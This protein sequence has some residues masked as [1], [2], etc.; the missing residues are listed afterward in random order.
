MTKI[1]AF[2]R[3]EPVATALLPLIGLLVSYLVSRGVLT[4]AAAPIILAV[5]VT[6]LGLPATAIVRSQVT[7]VVKVPEVTRAQVDSVI[8]TAAREL[9]DQL[10]PETRRAVDVL[11]AQARQHIGQHRAAE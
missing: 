8:G 10:G 4:E 11:A 9:G 1:V 5:V 2:V 3:K 7:P 6:A